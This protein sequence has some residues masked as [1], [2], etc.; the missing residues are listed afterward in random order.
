MFSFC[1]GN[2]ILQP[3]KS[4]FCPQ[5]ELKKET[6]S[7][8]RNGISGIPLDT[9]ILENNVNLNSQS[10]IENTA[11]ESITETKGLEN[12]KTDSDSPKDSQ[13]RQKSSSKSL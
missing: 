12:E 3:S 10:T 8:L 1:R 4:T 5:D 7:E 9:T 13:T 6:D 11:V 2:N